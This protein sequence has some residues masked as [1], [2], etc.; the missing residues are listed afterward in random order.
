M[1]DW[2]LQESKHRWERR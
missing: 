1:K 2:S